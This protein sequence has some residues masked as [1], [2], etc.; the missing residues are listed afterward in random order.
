MFTESPF[1]LRVDSYEADLDKDPTP[2][3]RL[4]PQER[5]A[6]LRDIGRASPTQ[7]AQGQIRAYFDRRLRA[8]TLDQIGGLRNCK[9][10]GPRE[11]LFIMKESAFRKL[12]RAK[13]GTSPYQEQRKLWDH[14]QQ[15]ATR[16][17]V[18]SSPET[19][20]IRKCVS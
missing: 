2:C 19:R 13:K 3:R 10:T 8:E 1:A 12:D 5:E 7:I 20:I 6:R 11:R 18:E 15:E 17:C 16:K 14:A 9:S 4:S